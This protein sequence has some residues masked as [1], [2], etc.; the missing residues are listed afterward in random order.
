MVKRIL[1]LAVTVACGG[2]AT[3]E[4]ID[5]AAE[6]GQH[7]AGMLIAVS[8]RFEEGSLREVFRALTPRKATGPIKVFALARSG[9]GDEP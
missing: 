8:R 5:F 1:A 9:A 7:P 6:L 2:C 3:G 4:E